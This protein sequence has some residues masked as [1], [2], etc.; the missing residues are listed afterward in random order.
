M[1][2][3]NFTHIL[4]EYSLQTTL[5]IMEDCLAYLLV[6]KQL[7]EFCKHVYNET[8]GIKYLCNVIELV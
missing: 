5:N 4:T 6:N 7:T 1:F 3:P 2:L 8:V